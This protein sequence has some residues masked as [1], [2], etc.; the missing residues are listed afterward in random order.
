MNHNNIIAIIAVGVVVFLFYT[1]MM[2]SNNI[3]IQSSY[4]SKNVAN[5]TNI[6]F[7]KPEHRL[8]KI[9]AT[10]SSGTKV[11]LSGTCTEIVYTKETIPKPLNDRIVY[12]VGSIVDTLKQVSQNDYYMKK[13]ENVYVQ[14]DGKGNQRYILDFFIYDVRNYYTIRLISDLVVVDDEIYMNYLNVQSGS[15]PTLLNKYDV[16]FNMM[17]ILFDANMFHENI[18]HLFDNYYMNAFKL[19]GIS[20]KDKESN[21][22]DMSEV[23]SLESFRNMYFPSNISS[24]TTDDYEAKGISGKL[25]EYLPPEQNT[26]KSP[27]FCQKDSLSWDTNGVPLP[28]ETKKGCYANNNSS[29]ANIT[30]PWFG[31]GVIYER[32]SNDA[33]SWLKDPARGNIIRASGFRQ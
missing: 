30:D 6:G 14:A 7:V 18:A 2:K 12:V 20:D 8:L 10:V 26:V 21:K 33:Y 16:K 31:P 17:G 29:L 24:L 27:S 23:Y 3:G 4:V 19:M 13:I 32:T 28:N 22:E 9:L 25:E 15:S 1:M 11:K 5:P